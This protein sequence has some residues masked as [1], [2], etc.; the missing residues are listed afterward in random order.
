MLFPTACLLLLLHGSQWPMS[1]LL[2]LTTSTGPAGQL[3]LLYCGPCVVQWLVNLGKDWYWL[4]TPS[5]RHRVLTLAFTLRKISFH[6]ITCVATIPQTRPPWELPPCVSA[7]G[8]MTHFCIPLH[9]PACA[10]T[11]LVS[12]CTFAWHF[13][14]VVRLGQNP[15]IHG[16]VI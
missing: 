6:F 3:G 1:L 9:E 10:L 13:R 11:I 5:D 15:F 16:R 8:H 14:C 12:M 4:S 7:V 2:I